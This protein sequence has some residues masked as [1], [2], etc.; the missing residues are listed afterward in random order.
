MR[1]KI[2]ARDCEV[3][4][5]VPFSGALEN[6]LWAVG[7]VPRVRFPT[8]RRLGGTGRGEVGG[9]RS[10]PE[11]RRFEPTE[12]DCQFEPLERADACGGFEVGNQEGGFGP[13]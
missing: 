7:R 8:R 5:G 13:V 9:G 3:V 4:W 12:S 10:R 2:A 1:R 11:K 6:G